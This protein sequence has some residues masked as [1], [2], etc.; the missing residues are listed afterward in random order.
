MKQFQ[1]VVSPLVPR[2]ELG[3]GD[4]GRPQRP[5]QESLQLRFTIQTEPIPLL[6]VRLLRARMKHG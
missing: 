4:N 6:L 1:L 2:L 5:P 3:F